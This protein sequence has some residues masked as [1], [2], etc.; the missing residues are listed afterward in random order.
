MINTIYITTP[1]LNVIS[2]LDRT[3]QSILMQAGDF[4]I[5]YHVQDGGSTD[6]TVE[7]LKWWS[8]RIEEKDFPLN[9]QGVDF[10]F[11]SEP[12]EG[13]YDAICKGFSSLHAGSSSFMTW[14]NADDMIMPGAF[15]FISNVQDQFSPEQISWVGGSV[16]IF[17]N[18]LPN[19]SHDRPI[20]RVMLKNGL[21]DGIHWDF[22]QQE[23]T[24]FRKF[25]WDSIK[26]E[27]SIKPLKL[28]GDWNIWRLFAKSATL[29]QARFPLGTFRIQP[30][31]LSDRLRNK[32]YNEIDSIISQ[33]KRR[34]DFY[35]IANE[36][37]IYR[38][39]FSTR[40]KSSDLEVYD[41]CQNLVLENKG[42]KLF[43]NDLTVNQS[44][45]PRAKVYSGVRGEKKKIKS[46]NDVFIRKDN[47]VAFN[48]DWQFPAI[49]EKNAFDRIL[50]SSS[51]I[52]NGVVYVG[53]PWATLIDKIQNKTS[54]AH[55]Y[56]DIFERFCR[57]LPKETKK[58][59][60]CQHIHG[61]N[62]EYLFRQ[63]G[64]N[65]VFW[66]HATHSD[67]QKPFKGDGPNFYPF[68]LY[69]VQVTDTLHEAT[70]ESDQV[71]RKYLYSFIGAKANQ[72]YLTEARNW[73][74]DLLAGD[75]RGLILGRNSWHYQKV[76]YDHQVKKTAGNNKAENLV[77]SSASN[78]FRE[79]LKQSTFSLCPSGSGPNSIRL[80]ESIGAGSI[81]VILADTWAP[82][83]NRSLWEMAT[84]FCKENPEEIKALPDRLAKIA[85]DPGRLVSM[86]HAMR[87][88][89]LLYGPQTFVTDVQEFMLS[90]AQYGD[91]PSNTN[92]FERSVEHLI[93]VALS[94]KS[95]ESLL[96]HCASSLLLEPARFLHRLE[97]D[98]Q[99][100]KALENARI[101]QSKDSALLRHFNAVL[102]NAKRKSKT[103]SPISP[104]IIRNIVPKVCL[105]GRHGN[106]TPLSYQPIQRLIGSGLE[107]VE[108]PNQADVLISGFNIDFKDNIDTLLPLLNGKNKPKLAVISEEPLWD[109]T[110]SGPF[111]GKGGQITAKGMDIEYT[112]LGHET[113][114]IFDF[115]RIPYFVLTSDSYS[116]RYAS[117]IARFSKLSPQEMCNRWLKASI[118]AAFFMEKRKGDA[119][120]KRFA[121][122]DVEALSAYRTSVAEYS[123]SKGVICVGRGWSDDARRQSL[124]DW[125]L[126]K[127]AHL[128]GRTRMLSAFENVHQKNYITE[129]FFDA[130]AVGAVPV[131]WASPGHRISDLV[132]NSSF[133]NTYQLN[134][135]DSAK[136]MLNFMPDENFAEAWL[137]SAAR[138]VDLFNDVSLINSER[139]RIAKSTLQ[140]VINLI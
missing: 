113:S 127:L 5:R 64:I 7:R 82:P 34:E 96:R 125:H 133:L 18:N 135:E 78:E 49:T 106:R 136:K 50:D 40:Y 43:G 12:D 63:A 94:S 92:S 61:K 95:A 17:L 80:W 46:F 140:S 131:Y 124:P 48:D 38:R 54:D 4:F 10:S 31:Q 132:S 79:S 129:K 21:C 9:C 25:L 13:M 118:P 66:S 93:N 115:D 27:E 75:N 42:R 67:N 107:F 3:I 112:F 70:S 60:V 20:P 119:Y 41:E 104:V 99:L 126:D 101:V 55:V 91:S 29:V 45:N 128:D 44:K 22:V 52:P 11:N 32:Y 98:I 87:Q 68:P 88:L 53:F 139:R 59:T 105:F 14:I 28:A 77:D 102:G 74:I 117:M 73:I 86:R 56:I 90:Q 81:P 1:C 35:K 89:W 65:H 69:P 137:H 120:S 83:G 76:V 62:Y 33:E 122:R 84:V 16:S 134:P 8:K 39:V 72:H 30:D 36:D 110:W 24:F 103:L 114:D 108:N 100:S 111:R 109:I 130:F 19:S 123:K 6:G 2:T 51:K 116:V 85:A 138:L 71:E 47:V 37:I 58:I 23:G 15:E 121:D 97:T 57:L 26:P